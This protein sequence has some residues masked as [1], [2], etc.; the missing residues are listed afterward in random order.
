MSAIDA[1]VIVVGCGPVG[2]MTALRCAQRGLRT[3]AIDKT[4]EVY[5][6][7]RAIGMD[8]ETQRL[9]QSA[10]PLS[11]L[12][13]NSTPLKGAE[14]VDAHNERVIGIEFDKGMIGPLAHPLMVAFDQPT[15][16]RFLRQA[17][18][19]AGVEFRFGQEAVQI[20]CDD[21]GVTVDLVSPAGPESLH[22]RWLIGADGASSTVRK[23][24]DI[25]LI[26]QGF[27]QEW[28][29]V[30]TTLTDP[31]LD[32][33][34]L[35]RQHCDPA[36]ICTFVPGHLSRRRWEFQLLP[37]E[38]REEVLEEAFIQDLLAPWGTPEQLVVDRAAVYRFHAT[39]AER[40]RSGP[41]F[42]AG[43]AGRLI[44]AIAADAPAALEPGYG[45][46]R[47]FPHIVD[48]V[49]DGDHPSVGRPIHQPKVDGRPLDDLL[50]DGWA[51]VTTGDSGPSAD[52]VPKLWQ[53]IDARRVTVLPES[54]PGVLDP[55]RT[56]VVRPDKYVAAVTTDLAATTA[57]LAATLLVASP[58]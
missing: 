13:A 5:P 40:F 53:E 20:R 15:V 49:V 9:F 4:P 31:D 41:V 37:H 25:A 56:I 22:G 54:L 23:L 33:P 3:L 16:E 36:R 8:D 34:H 50:G 30:D 14:F 39:V 38:T 18:A 46:G 27:D 58:C 26:D 12:R 48:S 28:L 24:L 42:L 44:D 32:L 7:P 35:A 55:G 21:A 45:G 2:V 43:D 29:V 19:D 57:R 17:A 51:L 1:D 47:P 11:E 10:G 52:A 6:L